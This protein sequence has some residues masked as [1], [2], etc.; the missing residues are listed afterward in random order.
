MV[1]IQFVKDRYFIT[2]PKSLVK[3]KA[4]NKGTELFMV[5]NEHGDIAIREVPQTEQQPKI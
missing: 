4:W 1:K 5:F 3:L 2:L